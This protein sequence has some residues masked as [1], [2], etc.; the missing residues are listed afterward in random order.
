MR[1]RDFIKVVA[2]PAITWPLAA[3]A[4]QPAIPVIGFLSGGSPNA[5]AEYVD[6]FR[7][8]LSEADYVVHRN[9]SIEYRWAEGEYERLPTLAKELVTA[10]VD[11]IAATGGS[12]PAKAAEEATKSI[13]IVFTGGGDPVG[14]GLVASLSHPGGNATGVTNFSTILESKR[15]E[16]L[17]QL[18]PTVN[19]IACLR[20]PNN[21]SAD[22]EWKEAQVAARAV[23]LQ[24]FLIDASNDNELDAGMSSIVQEQTRAI[25]VMSDVFF[26]VQRDRV[27]AFAAHHA[28]PAMYQFREYISAGG[29]ISY[30]TNTADE[31]RQAGIYAGKILKGAK[32]KDLPVIQPTKYE[33]VINLKT[34]KSLGLTILPTLLATADEVIE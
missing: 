27:I 10:K 26:N 32:P 11:L 6:A 29:L 28:I 18:L 7:Q 15:L 1:R 33:L 23:G 30:G 2:G 20:N 21:T 17:H 31:Y 14:L 19:R 9:V 25:L 34:A 13:P 12:G 4:Q 3:R 24:L 22:I 8:G 16:I 5:F